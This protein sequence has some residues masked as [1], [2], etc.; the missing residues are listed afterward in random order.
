MRM[1]PTASRLPLLALGALLCT[2][3]SVPTNATTI[4]FSG[5]QYADNFTETFNE[6][7]LTATDGALEMKNGSSAPGIALYNS[8]F[9][10]AATSGFNLKIDGKFTNISTSSFDGHSVGFLTNISGST[11]YLSVFRIRTQSGVS[12]A[13]FRLFEGSSINSTSAGT[14]IGTTL[15]LGP[16]DLAATFANNTFYTFSLD[17][18]VDTDANTISFTGSILDT[19]NGSIIGSFASVTDT[20]PTWGGTQVGLRVGTQGGTGRINTVDNFVLSAIPEPSSYALVGGMGVLGL[21]L[22]QRRKRN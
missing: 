3:A 22:T 19:T 7:M 14:Q 12:Y 18:A 21:A 5:T 15:V 10:A 1:T 11:G 16:T 8:A 20:T 17:V 4:D 13:D 2:A 6:S 9:P